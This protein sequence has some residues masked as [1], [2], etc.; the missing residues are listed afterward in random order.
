MQITRGF[1]RS[2]CRF[3][4]RPHDCF[5]SFSSLTVVSRLVG[6]LSSPPP[7]APAGSRVFNGEEDVEL[8]GFPSSGAPSTHVPLHNETMESRSPRIEGQRQC[9]PLP[10]S[11]S[12]LSPSNSALLPS[13]PPAHPREVNTEEENAPTVHPGTTFNVRL[14][15]KY[16]MPVKRSESMGPKSLDDLLALT[17]PS[18]RLPK[19]LRD[20]FARHHWNAATVVQTASI[21]LILQHHDLLCIA[22]TATGKTFAYAFPSIIRV[23]MGEMTHRASSPDE[24]SITGSDVEDLVRQKIKT[25]EI[26]KYCELNIANNKICLMTGSLHPEPKDAMLKKDWMRLEDLDVMATPRI[27]VLVPT[28]T[29]VHQVHRTFLNFKESLN[30]RFLVRASSAEEQK[31]FLSGLEGVD[32]LITTPETIIPALFKHKLSL[33]KLKVFIADEIDEIVS[34]NHFESLKIILAALPKGQ[35]RPQRLFFGASLPPVAYQMIRDRMLLPSHRFLL[36][37]QFK[38]LAP[39]PPSAS[40]SL[41][42]NNAIKHVVLTL[43]Q[44]EKIH[45]LVWLYQTERLLSDQRTIIFC[46]SRHNVAFVA[47]HLKKVMPELHVTTLSSRASDTAKMATLK[48][49]HSGVSTCL[50]CTDILSRGMDIPKVV[51]VVHYDMPL[52]ISTWMHRSGRCGRNGRPGYTYTFFQPENVRTA[53]PLVAYLRENK[54]LIPPKLQEYARQSFLDVFKNSLFH[55]PTRA[56]RRSDPQNHTPVLGRGTPRYPD[57]KQQQLLQHRRPH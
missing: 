10:S 50:V 9:T 7:P 5:T 35:R 12:S 52:E 23:L 32:V 42:S 49:F 14:F 47:D 39:G 4:S 13:T 11:S 16:G 1:G 38:T 44:T 53:K 34:S 43:S 18:T 31:K 17:P 46:N 40:V 45:K 8:Y 41:T 20:Y 6:T 19:Q 27:L 28:S 15:D 57:Y 21:P 2:L 24:V 30:V 33:S 36:I 29:L 51:Y 25:G 56:Y 26:C 3:I 48:L 22:P 55:H 54:Q 37:E